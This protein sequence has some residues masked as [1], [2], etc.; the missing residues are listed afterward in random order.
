MSVSSSGP[1]ERP[2]SLSLPEEWEVGVLTSED[3]KEQALHFVSQRDDA[4]FIQ[5]NIERGGLVDKGE[6]LQGTYVGM[7]WKNSIRGVIC[8]CWNGMLLVSVEE[9]V[10]KTVVTAAFDLG[11]M[12]SPETRE[13]IGVMGEKLSVTSVLEVSGLVARKLTSQ[14]ESS[15]VM[16]RCR[17]VGVQNQELSLDVF[18]ATEADVDVLTDW[19]ITCSS[20]ALGIVVS[21]REAEKERLR[22]VVAE[23]KTVWV[24]RLGETIVSTA[25]IN[26]SSQGR[27]M[28]GGVFTPKD[29]R[30]KG[31]AKA[32]VAGMLRTIHKEDPSIH[33]ALLFADHPFALKAYRRIGF[34]GCGEFC[35]H[36]FENPVPKAD[37]RP[38][39]PAS[40]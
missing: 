23:A 15:E 16:L 11:I 21:D 36:I 40:T 22:Q 18:R 1:M 20:E 14:T 28:I 9:T 13:I 2:L 26:A 4:L 35:L 6:E 24:L 34:T 39:S 37:L 19:S 5:S 12:K 31:Y 8:H 30:N 33:T 32:V 25:R 29:H 7:R 17:L 3:E 27:L 38:N 10:P